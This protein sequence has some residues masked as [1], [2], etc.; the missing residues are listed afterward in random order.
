MDSYISWLP[1]DSRSSTLDLTRILHTFNKDLKNIGGQ[2]IMNHK[3]RTSFLSM[4]LLSS[5]LITSF[6]S[7]IPTFARSQDKEVQ[8]LFTH[9][10]H[11]HLDPYKINKDG[12]IE[13]VGG[14]AKLKTTVDAKKQ[15]K[16]ATFLVDGGDFS[17]GTLY[18]TIYE[19]EAPELTLMGQIGYD[20]TTFGNHE[21]DYRSE[22]LSNMLHSAKRKAEKKPDLKLPALVSAN[23]DWD[24]N[25]SKD[26]FL[27]RSAME[28]YGSTPYTIVERGGVRV[29]MFGV[30]GE[31]ADSCAP[32]SGLE[33]E[34]IVETSKEVVKD[35]KEEDVDM[36]I[37]LS[38]SGTFEDADNSEDEILAQEVP[39]IDIIVSGHTH[40][41]LD[42]PIQYGNTY[43]VSAG[44]YC[45]NLGDI[46]LIQKEDG[47]WQLDTYELTPLT[48]QV[49]ENQAI[50][51]Q[52]A[53]YKETINQDYLSHFGYT[54]D[55]VIAQN[56]VDFSQMDSF[57][58]E[59]K[60]DPLGSIIADSYIHAVQQAEGDA[61]EK[62]HVAL[63]PSGVI[64][65]TFQTGN[66]T[67]SDA[68][69][70]S[71]L[72]IGADR[73]PGYPLVSVYLTGKE[74]K[75]IAEIDVSV[76]KI[77]PTAQLYPSGLRWTYNPNRMFLNRV[78]NVEFMTNVPYTNGK[79]TEKIE[80]NKLYRVIAGLYSAQMLGTVQDMSMGLLKIQPKDKEGNPIQDFEKVII[81]DQKGTEVK[82]WYA[83][84]SYIDSMK[85][86]EAGISQVS[87]HYNDTENRKEEINSKNP[88]ELLKNPN[89]F[90]WMLYGA[91][92]II[93]LLIVFIVRWF[94][95]RRKNK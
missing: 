95:K 39:E 84:A 78:T 42:K 54:F 72:G 47:R 56:A 33:F 82:E 81:H 17:M 24:K 86:N 85:E 48:A 63:T 9:D 76:S 7:P 73:I 55:Q 57:A 38:H 4:T 70:V 10:M 64:R 45:E 59:H 62:A 20:A 77:M 6:T 46:D 80:D 25:T 83:L 27:V 92:V 19:T 93:I 61:Y 68:F 37:C 26:N 16:E 14:F 36:I 94:L 32:E 58:M 87:S 1:N 66:I 50:T 67:V 44:C 30:L 91:I 60:E 40:T 49:K 53:S 69:N 2:Q 71:S 11:S 3:F 79:E 43:I 28:D 89:K 13:L 23:I 35:M 5:L 90:A 65:D 74:L 52:L 88:I 15:E 22:G 41:R 18:Q 12:S 75:T 21:F 8:V 51:T 34:D 29:G 31:D